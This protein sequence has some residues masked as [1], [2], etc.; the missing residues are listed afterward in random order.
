MA[1][2]KCPSL[3]PASALQAR[4]AAPAAPTGP[5][6]P[7]GSDAHPLKVAG[8]VTVAVSKLAPGAEGAVGLDKGSRADQGSQWTS[9][10]SG[11]PDASPHHANVHPPPICA[12]KSTPKHETN[13]AIRRTTG[14]VYR[15]ASRSSSAGFL[16]AISKGH[17]TL[18]FGPFFRLPFLLLCCLVPKL[19][20][21]PDLSSIYRGRHVSEQYARENHICPPARGRY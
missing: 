14:C 10:A 20:S 18:C 6:S 1:I 7:Q 4:S 16:N 2:A 21:A 5:N 3:V 17:L 9:T 15:F 8:P 12:S 19:S 11:Q 13:Q